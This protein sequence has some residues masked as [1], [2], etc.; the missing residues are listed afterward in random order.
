MTFPNPQDPNSIL[1][2]FVDQQP[3]STYPNNPDS[4]PSNFTT[5]QFTPTALTNALP[6][7]VTIPNHG[8]VNGNAIRATKFI[9]NP[10]GLATGMEQLNNRLFYVQQA[11]T[12]T[13]LLCDRNANF[14]DG[15]N[16]TPFISGGQFTLSGNT[17]LIVNPSNFPPPPLPGNG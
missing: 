4:S 6:I 15:R 17:T 2:D 7:V 12:N 5:T 1:Y 8:F 9:T 3:P 14:I 11:S 16:Y 10:P 13:F